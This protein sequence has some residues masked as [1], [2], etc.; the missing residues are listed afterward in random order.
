MQLTIQI[1]TFDGSTLQVKG[2]ITLEPDFTAQDV[3]F[4]RSFEHI[5][6]IARVSEICKRQLT[7]RTS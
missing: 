7:I 4:S 3:F 6:V 5:S 2:T 1:F